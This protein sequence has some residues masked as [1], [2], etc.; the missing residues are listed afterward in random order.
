[1]RQWVVIPI[2]APALCKTRLSSVL[3]EGG[4]RRLVATMLERSYAAAC[5]IVGPGQVLL[6]GPDRHGL[7]DSVGLLADPGG[8]LNAAL[9]SA[10]DA[11][12]EAGVDRVLFLSADLPLIQAEDV[13]AMFD[14]PPTHIAAASDRAGQG[15]NALCLPLPQGGRFAFRYGEDSF[16]AHH[17]E[18][19]RLSLGLTAIARP[20]LGFDVDQPDD[21]HAWSPGR[22]LAAPLAK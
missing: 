10:R 11:A 19:A 22:D 5:R 13:A 8:G 16:A 1:M 20:G 3:D 21:L 2:K 9:S 18:A 12:L 4:R 15:T 7:P 14:I 17:R 6:L